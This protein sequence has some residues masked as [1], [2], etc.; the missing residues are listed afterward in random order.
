MNN[1]ALSFTSAILIGVGATLT[2]DLWALFLN[3][4][5]KI[6]AR[7]SCLVGRWVDA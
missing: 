7:S 6:A 5:F 4:A 1:L 3:R 2:T